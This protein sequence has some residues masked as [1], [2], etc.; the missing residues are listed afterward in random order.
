[1]PPAVIRIGW[2]IQALIFAAAIYGLV[3]FARS[4]R[5]DAAA[6]L[7]APIVY[8]TA[9]HFPL[10]KEARQSLPAMPTVLLLA[11]VA[12]DDFISPRSAGS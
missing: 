10:L 9:V 3:V 5:A 1:M 12:I 4:G 7:A 8:V 6:L 2:A 11:A